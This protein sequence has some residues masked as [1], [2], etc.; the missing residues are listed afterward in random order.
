MIRWRK[1]RGKKKR[2]EEDCST[3]LNV[4]ALYQ[5]KWIKLFYFLSMPFSLSLALERFFISFGSGDHT[6][7]NLIIVA[8]QWYSGSFSSLDDT[9]FLPSYL[10]FFLSF[11]IFVFL[12]LLNTHRWPCVKSF[13]YFFFI[14]FPR[15][16]FFFVLMNFTVFP[17]RFC[18]SLLHSVGWW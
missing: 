11:Y 9:L 4:S 5:N 13:R 3:I 1:E 12:L 8:S 17:L 15:I 10:S 14:V 16:V 18:F 2:R 7:K 6:K